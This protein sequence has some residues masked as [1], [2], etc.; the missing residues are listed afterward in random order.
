MCLT[1]DG[2]TVAS[3]NAVKPFNVVAYAKQEGDIRGPATLTA[4]V[5]PVTLQANSNWDSVALP[6][7]FFPRAPS[8]DE[9]DDP[10]VPKYCRSRP[11]VLAA[12]LH[13][14]V[15]WFPDEDESRETSKDFLCRHRKT[16][17]LR[18]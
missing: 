15:L 16:R 3:L 1:T 4:T 17:V 8:P 18:P 11:V 5:A 14:V 13:Q 2:V 12:Q 6:S 7:T 10:K 9:Q